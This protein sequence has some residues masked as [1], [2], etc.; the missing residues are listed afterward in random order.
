VAL[1]TLQPLIGLSSAVRRL[2]ITC[3]DQD[4]FN[5]P[6]SLTQLQDLTIELL[7]TPVLLGGSSANLTALQ[8]L[9]ISRCNRLAS[10]PEAFGSLKA[11]QSLTIH[12][13]LRPFGGP[14]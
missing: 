14:P 7:Q 10:L 6:R 13:S 4:L 11:L 2:S 8:R 1:R 3:F 5:L 9:S 12:F